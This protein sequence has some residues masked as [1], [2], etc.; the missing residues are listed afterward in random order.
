MNRTNARRRVALVLF[1]VF[2]VVPLT[3]LYVLIQVGGL[4]GIWPTIALLV[5]DSV[6]GAW[7]MRR[8]G[9]RAWR[10]MRER[11]DTGRMPGREL[12]G[13]V[14]VVMGGALM[15]SP[16][17]VT[18]AFGILLVLPVTRPIFRRLLMAYAAGRVMV[19]VNGTPSGPRGRGPDGTHPG[20]A[21]DAVV[22]GEVIDDGQ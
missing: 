10:A 9:A 5:L 18:D 15:L 19:T 12:A 2:I 13:G 17:F 22:R 8:E 14:L 6:I 21:G 16:G 4:I 20:A 3:E 11:L 7:L 1:V